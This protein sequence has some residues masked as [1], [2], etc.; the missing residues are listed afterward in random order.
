VISAKNFETLL[1]GSGSFEE[2][3]Q[4]MRDKTYDDTEERVLPSDFFEH[5][6][7]GV[8]PEGFEPSQE[9]N[10]D[11]GEPT[12]P[13]QPEPLPEEAPE[14][15]EEAP[16]VPEPQ[17]EPEMK[18]ETEPEATPDPEAKAEPEV[19]PEAE[20][21]PEQEPAK[22]PVKEPT[23]EPVKEPVKEPEQT[24]T[25]AKPILPDYPE[26]SEGDDPLFD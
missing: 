15:P 2:Y 6:P 10:F 17:S 1:T 18:P 19:T 13:E 23:K 5:E 8:A 25:T 24:T 21:T 9:Q 14:A 16:A 3:F 26:G 22:E 4:Y 11:V 12:P 7:E 20:P